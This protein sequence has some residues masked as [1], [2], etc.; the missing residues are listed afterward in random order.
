MSL[1]AELDDNNIVIRTVVGNDNE[2]NEGYDWIVGNL[3][4][5][6]IKTVDDGSL[7]VRYAF[8]G[9]LYDEVRDA[10]YFPKPDDGNP[11]W[12]FNEETAQWELPKPV[13]EQV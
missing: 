10:F 13:E 8:A 5:R 2:S 1:W 4:G 6:W 11:D 12:F 3:G 7:R 9:M